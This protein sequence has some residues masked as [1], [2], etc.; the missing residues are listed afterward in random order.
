MPSVLS[1][2]QQLGRQPQSSA[3]PHATADII[4]VAGAPPKSCDRIPV[5][6]SRDSIGQPCCLSRTRFS[7]LRQCRKFWMGGS[8]QAP[9]SSCFFS[10]LGS[11]IMPRDCY[12]QSPPSFFIPIVFETSF[13]YCI[14]W[15]RVAVLLLS[16]GKTIR[17]PSTR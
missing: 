7:C 2:R 12:Q 5:T 17:S 1:L 3:T 8:R 13:L 15:F 11:T 6:L 9:P 14:R 10:S 4:T 16:L